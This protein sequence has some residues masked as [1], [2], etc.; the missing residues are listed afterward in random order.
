LAFSYGV[1]PVDLADEPDSW[2][3]LARDWLREQRLSGA[4]AMLV[5]G[6][7]TRNPDANHRI[8]FMRVGERP[9]SA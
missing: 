8:E 2:R 4:V 7:S 6:P 1:H 9:K 3:D 5:A